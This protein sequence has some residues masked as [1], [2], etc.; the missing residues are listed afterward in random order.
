[1]QVIENWADIRGKIRSVSEPG[2]IPGF[3]TALIDVSNV[4]PVAGFANLFEHANGQTVRINIPESAAHRLPLTAGGLIAFRVRR[5]GPNTAF[6][7][8]DKLQAEAETA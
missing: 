8:P 2:D 6:A 5:G 3:T 7:H 1:M 4:T